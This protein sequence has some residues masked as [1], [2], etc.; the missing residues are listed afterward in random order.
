VKRLEKKEKWKIV[1][2]PDEKKKGPQI[3]QQTNLS[4]PEEMC[5]PKE[6]NKKGEGC[7]ARKVTFLK[8]TIGG[9]KTRT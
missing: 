2:F 9:M 6:F 4:I 5:G 8:E 3:T 7:Q 1:K